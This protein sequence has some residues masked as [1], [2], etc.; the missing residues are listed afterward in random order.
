MVLVLERIRA[1]E[2]GKFDSV[3]VWVVVPDLPSI[4][5]QLKVVFSG[6]LTQ[7]IDA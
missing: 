3:C 5:Q 1:R 7:T 6:R 2:M 4:K